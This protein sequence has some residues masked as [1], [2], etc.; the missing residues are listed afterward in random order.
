MT[1]LFSRWLGSE[2]ETQN[3]NIGCGILNLMIDFITGHWITGHRVTTLCCWTMHWID[4]IMLL[5]DVSLVILMLLEIISTII[6]L[7]FKI[8]H[9]QL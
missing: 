9:A 7:L 3:S 6:Q 4:K 2:S 8:M 1:P 5:L